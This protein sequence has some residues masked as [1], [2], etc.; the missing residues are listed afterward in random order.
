M[1]FKIF[2]KFSS[3]ILP[4][5]VLL[6]S[7]SGAGHQKE[8]SGQVNE[9][10]ILMNYLEESGNIVNHPDI[11]SFVSADEVNNNLKGNNYHLIDLRSSVEFNLGHIENSVNV[12]PSNIL[13]YFEN[14]IEPNSFEK[15]ILVCGNS[16]LS[17]YTTAILRM[18]GYKNIYHIRFGLSSWDESVARRYWSANISSSLMGNLE[19]T[20]NSKSQPGNLPQISTGKTTGYEILRE[21]AQKALEINWDDISITFMDILENSDAYYIGNYWPQALYDLGHLP[22]AIQYNPKKSLH[23]SEDILTL[24]TDKPLV[25]YCYSGQNSA[26]VNAFFSIMGYDFRSLDYG[27]N[28]FIHQFIKETQPP[29][30]TFSDLHIRNYPLVQGGSLQ[31]STGNNSPEVKVET[32]VVQGGC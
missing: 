32:T 17:G 5:I 11:P 23:S 2:L 13:D 4:V 18:I 10:E 22:G 31:S 27:A 30:R 20:P 26:Y 28:G 3:V 8:S 12:P 9:A 24:P 15:I 1:K 7:C 6:A 29:G 25:F 14:R 16:H 19:T 21:R